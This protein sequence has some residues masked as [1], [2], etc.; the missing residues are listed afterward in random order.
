MED[1]YKETPVNHVN[2]YINKAIFGCNTNGT[3]TI[4]HNFVCTVY[5]I[6]CDTSIQK[7]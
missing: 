2:N 6:T 5:H 7:Q 1:A 4:P 3:N